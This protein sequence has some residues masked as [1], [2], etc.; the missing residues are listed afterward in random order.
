MNYFVTGATGFVGSHLVN[1]LRESGETEVYGTS[2]SGS[3]DENIRTVDLTDGDAVK[4][5]LEELK[6]TVIYHLAAFASPALSFKQPVVAVTSTLAMQINLYEACL[7]LDLKPKMLVVSS[8][9][10]YGKA[11]ASDLP[12]K[13]TSPLDFA[14]PY[15]VAKVGQE[16][17][18]AL[19][20]KRGLESI[21][22]RP[23]NHI[24]PGQQPGFLVPDLA[25]Q[26]AELEKGDDDAT[27]RVGNL[28]S[29]RDFTDVRDIVRAY[30][31][32]V[33]KGKAGEIYN[34]CTGKSVAGQDILKSLLA[35]SKN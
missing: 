15:S 12:L 3:D 30:V 27:L 24:G 7:A 9:Q 4:R 16:N 19:Y 34:V 29:K 22:A 17:L 21:I 10:I 31:M 26:I 2:M 23:M 18:A 32:L 20:A 25:K 28:S 35:L 13:E 8:G 33:E 6:P 5:L 1:L 11:E 14:S